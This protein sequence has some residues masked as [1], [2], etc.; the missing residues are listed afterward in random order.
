VAGTDVLNGG[1]GADSV[2]GSTGIN[3]LT[4]FGG[5]DFIGQGS[6]S[7]AGQVGFGHSGGN[8]IVGINTVG[9]SGAEMQIELAGTI[10]LAGGDFIF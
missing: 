3:H 8:T 10:N 7:A 2:Y 9:A 4:E 6:F 1:G 5:L